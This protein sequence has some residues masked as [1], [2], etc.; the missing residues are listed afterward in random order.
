MAIAYLNTSTLSSDLDKT[1]NEFNVA[2]TANIQTGYLLAFAGEIMK[3]R[4]IPVSGRVIVRRGFEG[5]HACSFPSGATFYIGTANDFKRL[6]DNAV[7]ILGDAGQIPDILIPGSVGFDGR[8][9]EYVLVDMTATCVPGAG[10]VIS[11]DGLYTAAILTSTSQGPVGVTMEDGTSDQWV[12][13]LRKGFHSHVKL[14]GGSS[15]HTS[16]GEFGG[17]SSVSSPAVGIVGRSSSQRSCD[18]VAGSV[19]YGMFPQSAC[20]TAS[21]SATSET[22]YYTTAWLE[23]PYVIRPVTS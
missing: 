3:V 16:L 12:W 6:R 20:T 2:S 10:V 21:T 13:V 4:S 11:R 15:L 22:G 23:Y 9:Y 14:V 17:A 8:G 19:I 1:T 18:P 5:T 7:G